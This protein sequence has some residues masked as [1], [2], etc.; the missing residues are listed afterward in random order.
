MPSLLSVAALRLGESSHALSGRLEQATNA[1]ARL[2]QLEGA[3]R[4]KALKLEISL[5]IA[6]NVHTRGGTGHPE[7]YRQLQQVR[8]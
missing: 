1:I 5:G 8:V 7:F 6:D 3:V 2:H 4:Q